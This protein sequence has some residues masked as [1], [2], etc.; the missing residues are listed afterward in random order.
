MAKT[1]SV[2]I[3]APEKVIYE[4][5]AYS[6]IVPGKLGYLGILAD[7]AP[8]VVQLGNGKITLRTASGDTKIID[9]AQGGF[10]EVAE[11]QAALL[12]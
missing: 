1:F 10:M 7:H 2:G 3:Y 4:G 9:S 6:L 8:M 12:L 5:Q 11:N